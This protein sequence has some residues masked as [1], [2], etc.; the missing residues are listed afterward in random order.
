MLPPSFVGKKKGK[1]LEKNAVKTVR[2]CCSI[3]I[4]YSSKSPRKK[5]PADPTS[6]TPKREGKRSV[7]GHH[8]TPHCCWCRTKKVFVRWQVP[9]PAPS[10]TVCD[11]CVPIPTENSEKQNIGLKVPRGVCVC[12]CVCVCVKIVPNQTLLSHISMVLMYR[13]SVKRET[14]LMMSQQVHISYLAF[15]SYSSL[16]GGLAKSNT[17]R[18]IP[19]TL[20]YLKTKVP[21]TASR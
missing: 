1:C 14:P 5:T 11:V 4:A 7:M 18:E 13:R 2:A 9:T 6:E 3:L 20:E 8:T 15:W 17:L 10:K 21:I 12:V 16:G 19:T